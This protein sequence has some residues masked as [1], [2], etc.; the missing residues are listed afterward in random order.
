MAHN[1]LRF[2]RPP[3]IEAILGV[4][5]APLPLTNG[6]LGWFWKQYLGDEWEHSVDAAPIQP[7]PEI[8]GGPPMWTPPGLQINFMP[9]PASGR[10]QIINRT[11][12]RMIQVQSSRLHYNW[13]KKDADYPS[14]RAMRAEFDDKFQSFCRFAVEARLGEVIPLQWEL[15]YID[16]VPPGEL[17]QTPADWHRV[18]PGLLSAKPEA[19]GTRLENLAG[20]WHFEIPSR[21]G[22]V[23]INLNFGKRALQPGDPP[24]LILQTTARGPIG[25]ETGLDLDAGL[26]LGH[27]MVIQTFMGLTSEEAHRAWGRKS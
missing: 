14:Y 17:W 3:I 22:R 18:L 4:Q 24:G 21:K 25:K 10:L 20:E 6:H 8:F 5:F 7:E 23:H 2:E 15:T 1:L 16:Y 12:D 26:E 9:I 13:Q 19:A 27:D 11:G